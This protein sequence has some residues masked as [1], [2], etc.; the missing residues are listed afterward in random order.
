MLPVPKLKFSEPRHNLP[1]R[2]GIATA[3][4]RF[5]ISFA[6]VYS[7]KAASLHGSSRKTELALA[8]EIPVNG[9]GIA[10]LITVSWEPTALLTGTVDDFLEMAR[11]TTRAFEFKLFDWKG[12]LTQATRYRFFAH[13]SILVLPSS[14]CE[15]A[16]EYIDTFFK[17]KIGLWSFDPDTAKI[18]VYHTPR[19]SLPK[20]FRN[21][22]D[23]VQKVN[24]AARSLPI[25]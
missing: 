10:D 9:F 20:S 24:R 18:E 12:G 17:I 6:R 13:Q 23:A 21:H 7:E 3:E 5:T 2:K 15:K 1:G 25:S 11:P 22:R 16:L 8:R 4:D 14:L 19:P